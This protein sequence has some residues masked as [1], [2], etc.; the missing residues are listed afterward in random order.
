MIEALILSKG[1]HYDNTDRIELIRSKEWN[2]LTDQMKAIVYNAHLYEWFPLQRALLTKLGLGEF[3]GY[4]GPV[5]HIIDTLNDISSYEDA[6]SVERERVVGLL[7]SQ[8]L[9]ECQQFFLMLKR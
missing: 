2:E 7:R 4:D 8:I 5:A 9:R 3:A 1:I 6:V